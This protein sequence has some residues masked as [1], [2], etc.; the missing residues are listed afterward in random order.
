MTIERLTMLTCD[1]ECDTHYPGANRDEVIKGARAEG[2]Q[3]GGEES[4]FCPECRKIFGDLR[5]DDDGN[6]VDPDAA[7]DDEDDDE[8]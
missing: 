7:F 2:W 8:A 5:K 3:I 1:G 6:Y 4:D